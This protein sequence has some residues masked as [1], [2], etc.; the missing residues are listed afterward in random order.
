MV[1]QTF[2]VLV[3]LSRTLLGAVQCLRF[4][5]SEEV[6]PFNIWV[7]AFIRIAAVHVRHQVLGI[8]LQ[9]YK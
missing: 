4:K 3:R 6:R 9:H 7:P 1:I 5:R 2:S 8:V